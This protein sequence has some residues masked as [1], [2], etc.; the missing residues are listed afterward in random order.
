MLVIQIVIVAFAIFSLTRV[1]GRYRHRSI[2]GGEFVLWTLFW[3]GVGVI[4]L[5]PGIT[6]R[7]AQI[8]GVG[9][10]A[11]AVFYLSLVVLFYL[12]FRLHLKNRALEQ[13]ITTLVRKLALRDAKPNEKD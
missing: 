4:V 7:F 10:G 5:W 12:V 9:R 8:L 13:Q 1:V 11:D 6:T 2:T 3:L